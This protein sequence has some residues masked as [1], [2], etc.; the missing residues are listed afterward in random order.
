VARNGQKR[1]RYNLAALSDLF[2]RQAVPTIYRVRGGAARP[3]TRIGAAWLRAR[4]ALALRRR[5][6]RDL[7]LSAEAF[8][9]LR[10]EREARMMRRFLALTRRRVVIL[11]VTRNETDW[12]ASWEAQIA[13]NKKVSRILASTDPAIRIDADWYF[14][15]AAI[16]AFW[17]GLG[18]LREVDFDAAVAE[19]G[20]IVPRLYRAAGID[21]AGLAVDVRLNTRAE[22]R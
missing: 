13:K 8:S 9:F 16:R 3:N 17:S 4:W 20:N 7:I 1:E 22:A 19:D 21:L 11:L 12:R 18:E 6:E 2:I 10:T 14:D 15:L 5:P